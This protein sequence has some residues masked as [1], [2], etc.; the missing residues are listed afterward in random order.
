MRDRDAILADGTHSRRSDLRPVPRRRIIHIGER[1]PS[2][3]NPDL[4][5]TRDHFVG[6][7]T[8]LLC[9]LIQRKAEFALQILP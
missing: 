6:R 3:P 5:R 8:H 9:S 1:F 2:R 4:K 7:F